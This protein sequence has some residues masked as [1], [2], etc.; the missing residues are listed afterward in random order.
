MRRQR[1]LTIE[2]LRLIAACFVVF[3]HV[4][5]PDKM[6]SV[7]ECLARF[8]V[9]FFFAVTGYF[10]FRANCDT[11]KR[12]M[13]HILKLDVI[14]NTVYLLWGCWQACFING[15]GLS[16]YL[17]GLLTVKNLARLLFLNLTPF[18]SHLW[19]LSALVMCYVVL[20]L[21]TRFYGTEPV[22]Y[23]PL[24]QTAVLLWVIN[25]CFGAMAKLNGIDIAYATGR[26]FLFFGIPTIALGL[27]LREYQD[28]M[29][30]NFHWS[31]RTSALLILL[32]TCVS[33]TERFGIG[34]TELSIGVLMTAVGLIYFAVTHP[35]LPDF[36]PLKLLAAYSGQLSLFL[37]IVHPL[38]NQIIQAY[39]E[40]VALFGK[41]L[42]HG[43]LYPPAIICFSLA[44]G[45][46]DCLCVSGWRRLTAGR[47]K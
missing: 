34:K 22:N 4:A 31:G 21:Y 25:Y 26:N 5:F 29:L 2:L 36:P 11:I 9:P 32:G 14:A 41:F 46:L 20:W 35:A 8:A 27:F 1:N 13:L 7:V 42:R 40:R 30:A 33:L 24:Y 23:R 10:N 43:Y 17:L 19:Y 18:S 39:G 16:D 47:T 38:L 15:T 12:R 28:R 37:Y 44:L 6:W 45:V 3:I